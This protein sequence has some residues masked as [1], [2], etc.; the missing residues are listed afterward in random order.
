M[1][2]L[3]QAAEPW[4]A[5]VGF[6]TLVCFVAVVAIVAS[7]RTAPASVEPVDDGDDLGVGDFG[8]T[9]AFDKH[10]ESALEVV[11]DE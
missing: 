7:D 2:A 9:V 10:A 4:L 5:V 6:I 3:W 1:T 8:D 11:R